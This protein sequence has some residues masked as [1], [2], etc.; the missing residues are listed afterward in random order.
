ML[1]DDD[2]QLVERALLGLQNAFHNGVAFLRI[3][4]QPIASARKNCCVD[5]ICAAAVMTRSR[6]LAGDDAALRKPG[7]LAAIW[8]ETVR[9][10]AR[11]SLT[12]RSNSSCAYTVIRRLP[13]IEPERARS[14]AET[15]SNIKGQVQPL[16]KAVT[17]TLSMI[18]GAG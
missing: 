7:K 9:N 15:G 16:C 12:A 5:A 8:P 13:S 10:C 4:R 11:I 1:L 3:R 18:D 6:T 2:R 14:P 17:W